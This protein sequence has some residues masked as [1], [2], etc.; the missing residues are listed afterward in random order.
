MSADLPSAEAQAVIA[1]LR[2]RDATVATAESLTGGLLCST[3]VAV[4]GASDV[5]RGG[6]VAYA[7]EVKVSMLDV[8]AD[9]VA[10]AGTVDPDTTQAMA[11][12]VRH[13]LAA[14]YGLATTGVA[15]PDPVEGK[16]VGL[17]FVAVAGPGGTCVRRLELLGDRLMVR[18]GATVAALTLLLEVLHAAA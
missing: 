17:V 2:A 5:V 14:D 8:P 12:G 10:R 11:I 6:V 1:A 16:A 9:L 7:A 4:P 13:R 3:L 18:R 15:G